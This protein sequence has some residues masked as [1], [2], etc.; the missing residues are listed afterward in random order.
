MNTSTASGIMSSP[1]TAKSVS[2]KVVKKS[3]EVAAPVAAPAP[4]AATP[5]AKKP[6][7]E[8][9]PVAAE[10]AA[11]VPAVVTA[12]PVETTEAAVVSVQDDVK[13][14]LT[15]ASTVRETV[16]ALVS[17]L[18]RLEKRVAK[19]QKEADKRRRKSKKP[20]EGE[21][22]KERK[23]SIFEIPTP[24][25]PELCSFL[26]VSNGSKESRSNVT[27]A[28]TAYVK[29]HDLKNKHTIVP[30]SKLKSLLSVSDSDV[31]TYFNLQR[32][33]NRHY[34]KPAATA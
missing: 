30:D 2:K 10:P 4:V 9:A 11:V 17:E 21:P 33:L 26:G 25:S 13:A 7:K 14:M 28:V 24:L 15:Q 8:K 12:A 22:V 34:L 32:Y 31:L 16:G 6:K 3:E 18:K 5:E 27:K 20:V 1:A 23:P 29:K 19:L